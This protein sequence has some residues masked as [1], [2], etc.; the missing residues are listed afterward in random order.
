MSVTYKI[1]SI[2]KQFDINLICFDLFDTIVHRKCTPDMIK[3]I[4]AK[5]IAEEINYYIEPSEIY[6]CRK[7]SE[8][9]ISQTIPDYDYYAFTEEFTKRLLNLGYKFDKESFRLHLLD[10]E[11]NC[12][13]NNQY[14]DE[15]TIEAIKSAH[16]KGKRIVVVSDFYLDKGSIWKL[17]KYHMIDNYISEIYVSCECR[18]SKATGLLYKYVCDSEKSNPNNC[19]MIG[20]NYKRD[21]RNAIQNGYKAIWKKFNSSN[22][23]KG[24]ITIE[25]DIHRSLCTH[26]TS[27]Y[28]LYIINIYLFVEKLYIELI[29]NCAKDVYFFSREGEFLKKIFDLY[30][31]NRNNKS[32]KSH[33]VYISRKSTYLASLSFNERDFDAYFY[34]MNKSNIDNFLSNLNFTYEEKMIVAEANGYNDKDLYEQSYDLKNSKR[35]KNIINSYEFRKLLNSKIQDAKYRLENYF[36]SIGMNSDTIY[37]VDIGWKGTIQDNIF[38]FFQKEKKIVGYYFGLLS[39]TYGYEKCKKKGL[40]FSAVPFRSKNYE[41]FSAGYL[42][43]EKLLMASHPSTSSY[44]EIKGRWEP[45]FDEKKYEIA[46]FEK[47][48]PVQMEMIDLFLELDKSILESCFILS[49]L[50]DYVAKEN[51]NILSKINRNDIQL[52]NEIQDAHYENFGPLKSQKEMVA[53]REKNY[54][55]KKIE[56]YLKHP[57]KIFELSNYYRTLF[58]LKKMNLSFFIPIYKFISIYI[59][60]RNIK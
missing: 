2:L 22:C 50:Q 34:L 25:K 1:N 12:E 6:Q 8:R 23:S 30:A 43:Y 35:F 44:K 5:T 26:T 47:I 57:H 11:L 21:Y 29:R 10:I 45:I 52:R 49:D 24:R 4:W 16:S 33:Y 20:D 60:G 40:V 48:K 59:A 7:D 38:K 27:N 46:A 42:L 37:I 19:L 54:D 36:N 15:A 53:A 14:V 55:M 58:Q 13:K 28:S 31:H 18:C 17:L 9:F 51:L 39:Y 56:V 41:V 32:I 3:Q